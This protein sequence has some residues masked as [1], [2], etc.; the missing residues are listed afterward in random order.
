MDLPPI[1]EDK[2]HFEYDKGVV[3]IID[4]E[5]FM[6]R[7]KCRMALHLDA[8]TQLYSSLEEKFIASVSE[9]CLIKL[10]SKESLLVDDQAEPV[11]TLR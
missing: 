6:M 1:V 8:V 9:D 7:Q 4:K 5:K 2:T 10:W 11:R 3:K